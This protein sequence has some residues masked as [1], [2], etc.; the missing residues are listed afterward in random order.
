MDAKT[1]NKIQSFFK[2]EYENSADDILIY[3][4]YFFQQAGLQSHAN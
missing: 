3:L 4:L 2:R 1:H